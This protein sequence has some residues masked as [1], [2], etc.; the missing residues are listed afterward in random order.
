MG[1]KPIHKRG[2]KT[3]RKHFFEYVLLLP[4]N[5]DERLKCGYK[6]ALETRYKYS[7]VSQCYLNFPLLTSEGHM[8]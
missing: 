7:S 5:T 3:V 8:P 1:E 2:E 6:Y 4:Q